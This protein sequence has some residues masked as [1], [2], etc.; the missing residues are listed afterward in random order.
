[1]KQKRV[2]IY[3]IKYDLQSHDST[4][5][6][7]DRSTMKFFHQTLKDFSVKRVY[8]DVY[9]ITAA[10][11]DER[12]HVVGITERY[13]SMRVHKM[14]DKDEEEEAI[15]AGMNDAELY[16]HIEADAE[17]EEAANATLQA[18]V[19]RKDGKK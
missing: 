5:H 6:F 9:C 14:F 7:F 1:M 17:D 3:D 4:D 13:Y 19:L 10:M 16:D 15:R 18:S 11:R 12:G 2:T 8:K